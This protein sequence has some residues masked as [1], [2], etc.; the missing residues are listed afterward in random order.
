MKATAPASASSTWRETSRAIRLLRAESRFGGRKPAGLARKP[1]IQPSPPVPLPRPLWLLPTLRP[2]LRF[3]HVVFLCSTF[4]PSLSVS[5]STRSQSRPVFLG[6]FRPLFTSFA[7]TCWPI[8]PALP[9][10]LS[11]FRLLFPF[12]SSLSISRKRDIPSL[13][14]IDGLCSRFTLML[15]SR[16]QPFSLGIYLVSTQHGLR[17][18]ACCLYTARVYG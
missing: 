16:K 15:G 6:L 18:L 3:S 14:R 4:S 8:P 17:M 2:P 5:P 11:P 12:S 7:P 1:C 13:P 10:W 9:V